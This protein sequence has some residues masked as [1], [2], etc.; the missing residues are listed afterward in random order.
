VNQ[1]A[2]CNFVIHG[3]ALKILDKPTHV[4]IELM[5]D[6]VIVRRVEPGQRIYFADVEIPDSLADGAGTIMPTFSGEAL[7]G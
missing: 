5:S 2:D 4:P 1:C 7:L 6:A 3:E